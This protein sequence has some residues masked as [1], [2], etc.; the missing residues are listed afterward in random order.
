M[1]LISKNK[2][3]FINGN[4]LARKEDDPIFNYL[5]CCNSMVVSWITR[6]L[7]PQSVVY[8][9]N[10][11]VLWDNLCHQF[12]KF[13]HFKLFD[14]LQEIHSMKQGE[15]YVNEFF[16]DTKIVCENLENLRSIPIQS[17]NVRCNCDAFRI[18]RNQCE[19]EYVIRF[20]KGLYVD[21]SIA[22]SQIL[23]MKPLPSICEIFSLIIKQK[24][25][26]ASTSSF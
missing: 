5:E 18:M 7:S 4:L 2:I 11:K 26:L 8:I 25:H 24:D 13:T 14:L 10:A 1:F 3:K 12:T 20:L 6:T 23:L 16:T 22:R 15:W 19:I 9:D 17:C 21:Y